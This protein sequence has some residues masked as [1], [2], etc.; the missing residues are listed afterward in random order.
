L[1]DDAFM[2]DLGKVSGN[3]FEDA[4]RL[5]EALGESVAS[6]AEEM[7][8]G[9]AIL[10]SEDKVQLV[11]VECLFLK[12]RFTDGDFGRYVNVAVLT[13]DGRKLILNDGSTGICGQ[14]WDYTQ[15]TGKS[16]YGHAKR[17]LRAS[18][19]ATCG[20]KNCGVPRDSRDEEC[21]TCGD[22]DTRRGTGTTL[23]ID[24]AA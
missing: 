9:F 5:A 21:A 14:L 3:A 23:Y 2:R 17:G 20:A 6:F 24:L 4:M 1:I 19:Y 18:T 10:A 13:H 15:A 7:G 8:N 16:T 22:T 11:G 12:W